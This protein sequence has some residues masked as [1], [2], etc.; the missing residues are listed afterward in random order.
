MS[1]PIV[2]LDWNDCGRAVYDG[3]TVG[4][5]VIA[6]D[7]DRSCGWC[8]AVV[9]KSNGRWVEVKSTGPMNYWPGAGA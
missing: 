7:L 5:E 3:L 2:T 6:V 1:F 4:E 9:E 8:M